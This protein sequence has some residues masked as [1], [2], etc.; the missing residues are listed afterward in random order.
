MHTSSPS[1][2][3]RRTS[4]AY[5]RIYICIYIYIYSLGM[6]Y[7]YFCELIEFAIHTAESRVC[8]LIRTGGCAIIS[9][10]IGLNL[11]LLGVFRIMALILAQCLPVFKSIIH[12]TVGESAI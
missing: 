12:R 8:E 11:A 9:V 4:N 2:Y 1:S 10:I 5:G 3:I 7:N 6:I